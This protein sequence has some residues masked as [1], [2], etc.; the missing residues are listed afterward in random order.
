MRETSWFAAIAAYDEAIRLQPEV[1]RLY[2]ARGT[3]YMYAGRHDSALA[4]YSLAIELDPTDAGLWRRRSHAHT[5]EP[6]P[7]ARERRTGRHS[8]RR[9]ESEPP[10]GLRPPRNCVHAI[11][12]ARLA[13]RPDG[14]GPAH[15][16]VPRPRPGGIQDARVDPRQPGE[17]GGSRTGPAI[18]P[19]TGG[20]V[21]TTRSPD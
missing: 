9:A 6:T 18:G 19:L 3:A 8:G 10:H 21:D 5:I 20:R 16:T 14:H 11:A 7:S 4:D 13:E 17:P 1:T 2:E 12:D 15:R